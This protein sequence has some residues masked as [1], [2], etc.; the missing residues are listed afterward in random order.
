MAAQCILIVDDDRDLVSVLSMAMESAGYRVGQ[1]YNSEQAL[2]E[3]RQS[4]PD[5]A[6]VDVMMETIGAGVRLTHEFR[7]DPKLKNMRIIML[8]A[9]NQRLPVGI[10]A[11]TE[12]GY[13]PV[14]KFMEK[15]VDPADLLKAVR[16]LLENEGR[17]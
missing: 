7:C 8:T 3:A 12:E 14:D 5:L 4:A 10:G 17:K 16:E 15:P 13:L 1:A 9:I 2:E 6:I 11:E